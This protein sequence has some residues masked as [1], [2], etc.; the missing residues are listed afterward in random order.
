MNS[1]N[2][3]EKNKIWYK[4]LLKIYKYYRNACNV[5]IVDRLEAIIKKE[6]QQKTKEEKE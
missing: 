5:G 1:G 6:N 2:N 3:L 4:L